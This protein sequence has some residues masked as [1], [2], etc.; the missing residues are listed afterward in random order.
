MTE[1]NSLLW[2]LAGAALFGAATRV[3]I[4]PIAWIGLP[5][6]VHASRSMK[7]MPDALY[8]WIAL[9][10]SLAIVKRGVLPIQGPF[11][12]VVPAIEATA[13]LS[14]LAFDRL[15]SPSMSGVASTLVLPIALVTAEFLY[16]RFTAA[17]SWGSIAYSQYGFPP[18]MQVAAIVGIWGI[19]FLIAWSASTFELALSRGF[20]LTGIRSAVFTCA[21]AVSAI[22]LGGYA[23]LMLAPTDRSAIRAVTL[24]RPIGLFA[25]GEMT[26][27]SEGSVSSSE[28]ETINDK[29]L[30]LRR[31]FLDGTRREAHAGARLVVWPEQNLLIFREDEAAF[32]EEARKVA[33]AEHVY[34]AMGMGTVHPGDRL[35]LENKLVLID[36]AGRIV[37]SH[38]KTRPV[39][40]WEESIMK[41]GNGSIPVV[42]TSDGRMAGAICFEADF[43]DFIRGAGERRADLLIVPVNEWKEI[44]DIHFRMHVFRAIE[45]GVPLVRAAASGLSA[46]IDPWGRV[47]SVSDFWA[48]GD[49][50]MT[51]QVP[52]GRVPTLYARTG[53]LFAWLCVAAV[54]AVLA[55]AVV[56]PARRSMQRLRAMVPIATPLIRSSGGSAYVGAIV[57]ETRLP[58]TTKR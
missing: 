26:R 13:I 34:L 14:V 52:V 44:K 47:L 10:A 20:D 31:S 15:V 53:D 55:I 6:I 43:P 49:R 18:L 57:N 41:R 23:R 12:F 38:L 30:R 27:I 39:S 37:L 58:P 2:S 4:P 5:V 24:N 3:A 54:A 32:L 16:S 35:P 46:A 25:P 17:A 51:A 22:V 50:T 11:Y 36:P 19:T 28:R 33:A 56:I 29:L 48:A 40:G 8:L 7:L 1:A 42:E 21:I 45:N 9:Y